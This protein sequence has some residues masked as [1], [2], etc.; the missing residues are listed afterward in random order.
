MQPTSQP[1]SQLV[2]PHMPPPSV[3][4]ITASGKTRTATMGVAYGMEREV[5]ARPPKVGC[6]PW[7][8]T[9]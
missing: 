8:E 2:T 6:I 3:H 4:V 7:R 5:Y 1:K 9:P